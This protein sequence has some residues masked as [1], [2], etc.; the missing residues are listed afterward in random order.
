MQRNRKSG[1]S[2]YDQVKRRIETP[3]EQRS[4]Y[5]GNTE[6]MISTGSTLLDL[7]ISGGRIRGGGIPGGIVVEIFGPSGT[8]KTVLLCEIAGDIQRKGG[9]VLFHDP[10]ARLN[11]QFAEIFGLQTEEMQYMHPNTVTEVFTSIRNWDPGGG[12]INGVITD[13]LA[14]LSTDL[15][16]DDEEGDK[17]GMR[18][19]KEF[20]EGFRRAARMIN[21]SN[22][23]MVCS[24]QVRENVEAGPYGQRSIAPGG[25]AIGFYSSLRLRA[26]GAKKLKRKVQIRGKDYTQIHG[27]ETEL[28]VFKSSIWK[29]HRTAFVTIDYE[30]GIDDVRDNLRFVKRFTGNSTF[31]F[32]DYKLS[33]GL[34]AAISQVEAQQLQDELRE[35]VI[36]IW[37]DIEDK[38]KTERK[39]KKR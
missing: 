3:K 7:A 14:A 26:I 27:V 28:E 39:P 4:E 19:A 25:K 21:E 35:E 9:E 38:F 5:S 13:S 24:N 29:P 34:E 32:K 31:G 23:L 33:N 36:D 10:E 20:S 1:K 17:M 16:M 37:E 22:L 18:R 8:G 30:I 12:K 2:I 15:E 11:K 6:V